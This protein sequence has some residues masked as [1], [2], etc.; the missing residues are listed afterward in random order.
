MWEAQFGDFA[1]GAQVIIDQFITSSESKWGRASGLVMLLPHGY[2]GQGPEHSSA[3]LERFLQ[4]CA[5]ENVQVVNCT[6]PSNYF[7]V[8]RRQMHREFRKPL[9]IMTPKSLLR[10]KR[11]VSDISEFVTKSSFHRVLEDD[12]YFKDNKLISLKKN[13]KIKKVVMCSGK[14]YYDLLEEREKTKTNDVVFVRLEQLYPFPAKTL[15]KVLKSY[16]TA[17]F[18]W[19][20]EEPKNMGAWNTV[21]NYIDRTL[22]MINFKDSKVIFVGRSASSTTATGNANKHLAQQKE[23]LEKIL[24]H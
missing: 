1:N 11:C 16:K 21:R 23:I 22:E 7:H 9:I 18:I 24:K 12:A 4:L 19:C 5:G 6:T 15:A 8:L 10:H 17:K 13:N 14:I 20:Q 2:E 3:R